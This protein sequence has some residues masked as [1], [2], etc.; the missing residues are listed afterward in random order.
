MDIKDI[1]WLAGFLEGEGSFMV[2]SPNI[3]RGYVNNRTFILQVV[4]TDRDVAEKAKL[5][6][7]N[8]S[9]I[10][11]ERTSHKTAYRVRL[12]GTHAIAWMMTLYSMMGERRKNKIKDIILA[13]RLY[14]SQ[15]QKAFA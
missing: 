7:G 15:S 1:Y 5:L 4:S 6:L 12:S 10:Q 3:N 9:C 13:W 2:I 8:K 11:V 14:S